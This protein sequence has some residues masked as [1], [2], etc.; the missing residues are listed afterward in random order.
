MKII[1]KFLKKL[2]TSRNTFVTYILTMIS[3]YIVVDRIVEMLFIIFTGV[4]V[5]YWGPIQYTL[6]LACP[7]FAFLFSPTSEFATSKNTKIT[8]FLTYVVTLYIIAISMF[9]Q[10]INQG[11]WLLLIS[12]P[13]YTE[14]VSNFSELIRPALTAL[15]IYLPLTTFYG[16]FKWCHLGILDSKDE[17]RSIWDYKGISLSEK[18]EGHGPFTCDMFMCNNWEN[19]KKMIFEEKARYQ[20]LLVCGGSGTGKT[21]LILEPMMAKDIEKKAFYMANAKEFGYTALKTGIATLNKPY[22]NEYLNENFNLNMITPTTGKETVYKAYMNKMI[23][24]SIGNDIVYRNLGLTAISPDFESISRIIDVCKNYHIKYN[25]IDPSSVESI[26]LNPFVYDDPTK[27]AITISSVLKGMHTSA[28]LEVREVY[29]EDFIIQALENITIMLKEMYPRMNEGKLPNLED[30]QKM[31]TNFN[32]V[33]KMSEIMNADSE[34]SEKYSM[35]I[36]YFKKNFYANSS[37][38]EETEKYIYI[39]TA[40][41]DNLLRMPGVKSILCNRYNNIDFDKALENGEVT[42]VCTRRGD[43]GRTTNKAFGLFFIISMQN[44]VL[45]RPGNEN[46]RIPHFFYIDEFSDFICKDTEAIFT[47]YRKYKVGTTISVQNLAQLEG[48]TENSKNKD[49][50]LSNCASKIFLGNATPEELE[51]WSKEFAM[52]REWKYKNSMDME[53]LKYDSKYGDVQ[54]GWSNYFAINKLAKIKFKYAAVKLK[55]NNGNIDIGEGTFNF[56]ASKYKEEQPIKT[57]NFSRFTPGV[58]ASEDDS[59]SPTKHKF[60]PRHVS[61]VD[62]NDEVDPVQM[63]NTDANFEFDNENAIVVNFK[64][65]KQ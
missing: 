39:A 63:N 49:I 22:D 13:G 40:Q 10:G 27:I 51:W 8:L 24:S 18:K 1:D 28:H 46:S 38:R 31:L 33:Q 11:V 20:S 52:K 37:G 25:L 7:V 50:I 9:V 14:L 12:L 42:L 43:L 58:A 29:R 61:F 3:L 47:I 35:Q 17:S 21:S 36:R 53:K 6:A 15:G 57:Y 32:L 65:K 55:M 44:A 5:S 41:L 48:E 34:L 45:R 2:N 59:D 30:L 56:I 62:E 64:K 16:V 19:G 4:G 26:G 60:D 23:L 54:Y